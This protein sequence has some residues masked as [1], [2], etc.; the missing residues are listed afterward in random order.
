M[1]VAWHNVACV[2]FAC[3]ITVGIVWSSPIHLMY[4][5]FIAKA[6][7]VNDS[8]LRL[9]NMFFVSR[10]CWTLPAVAESLDLDLQVIVQWESRI[11]RMPSILVRH[12]VISASSFS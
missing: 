2:Y 1:R 8:P 6:G 7:V 10:N 4:Q 12:V 5:E 11:C 3:L 9:S